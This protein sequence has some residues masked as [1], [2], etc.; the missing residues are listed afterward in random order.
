MPMERD[1]DGWWRPDRSGA[2]GRGG[3]RLRRSRPAGT[4]RPARRPSSP[5]RARGDS[6]TACT[7]ARA[8]ST[9][10]RPPWTDEAWT[11]RQL[12]G[13][14]VYELHVGT[15]TPEGT[16]DAAITRLDHL[17][18]IGVD[19]VELMPVNALQRRA[20]LGLR[21]RRCG[22]RCTR[23][24]AAPRRTSGSSTPATRPVSAWCRTWSTTTSA[25]RGTT[26]RCSGPTSRPR[27]TNPWGAH[28]NLDGEDSHEVRAYI[29]DNVRMWFEDFHVDALRLDA[30][31]ALRRLLRRPPARGRRACSPRGSRP[32]SGAR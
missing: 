21:R 25:R 23:R 1:D 11:G 7:S 28:V 26:C 19:L 8:P 24:T 5:T 3:L 27:G 31:H 10:Q 30:V 14:V 32:S 20:R 15:F 9:R 22:S 13:S 16:L 12:A 6:R 29:L 18:S 4:A 2:A 17:R